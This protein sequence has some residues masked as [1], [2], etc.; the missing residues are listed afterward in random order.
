MLVSSVIVKLLM[1][2]NDLLVQFKYT[3]VRY[4]YF[5]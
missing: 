3:T 5:R 2:D 1:A 4:T